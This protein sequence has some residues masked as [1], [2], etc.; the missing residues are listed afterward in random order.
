MSSSFERRGWQTF[1]VDSAKRF[2]R[3]NPDGIKMEVKSPLQ[4]DI[5]HLTEADIKD[6]AKMHGNPGSARFAPPCSPRYR[7]PQTGIQ[8]ISQQHGN[9]RGGK[10]SRRL[11]D[12]SAFSSS[13]FWSSWIQ[14]CCFL[15]KIPK[16]TL[17]PCVSPYITNGMYCKVHYCDYVLGIVREKNNLLHDNSDGNRPL[18]SEHKNQ[19]N[20][21][22]SMVQLC[23]ATPTSL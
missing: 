1:T 5:L 21:M 19:P 2:W 20:H 22:M 10:T 7:Q 8:A 13:R 11:R 18:R 14:L 3:A 4:T 16:N 17:L 23:A 6:L 15:L 12:R 9:L